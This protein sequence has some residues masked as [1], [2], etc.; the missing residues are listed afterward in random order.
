MK[1]LIFLLMLFI[2]APSFSQVMMTQYTALNGVTM[3]TTTD[4]V[5]AI[6]LHYGN[7][8]GTFGTQIWGQIPDSIRVVWY[9]RGGTTGDSTG[10]FFKYQYLINSNNTLYSLTTIDSVTAQAQAYHTLSGFHS[11]STINLYAVPITTGHSNAASGSANPTKLWLYLQY[12]YHV[13]R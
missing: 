11:Y 4:S 9:S 2:A 12:F 1:K 13:A 10:N 8:G 3:T 5:I 7:A 6:P